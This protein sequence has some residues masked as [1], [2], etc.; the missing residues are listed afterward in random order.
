MCFRICGG[1]ELTRCL[2]IWQLLYLWYIVVVLS[3]FGLSCRCNPS[4]HCLMNCYSINEVF[5]IRRFQCKNYHLNNKWSFYAFRCGAQVQVWLSRW[6]LVIGFEK[7]EYIPT[8]FLRW[9]LLPKGKFWRIYL[10]L[11]S[12]LTIVI[13]HWWTCAQDHGS[14]FRNPSWKQRRQAWRRRTGAGMRD[15][16]HSYQRVLVSGISE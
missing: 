11:P 16:S 12:T 8:F 14:R 1:M 15:D 13:Y 9:Y 6:Y 2:L 4:I 5:T 10:Y 7:T 3:L